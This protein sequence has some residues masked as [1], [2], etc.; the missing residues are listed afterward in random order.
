MC[1]V[2]VKYFA[3][4]THQVRV[5]RFVLAKHFVLAPR[6]VEAKYSCARLASAPMRLSHLPKP[7]E[8]AQLF[9]L[10]L[11]AQHILSLP[12][13]REMASLPV[14]FS[15]VCLTCLLRPFRFLRFSR[16]CLFCHPALFSPTSQMSHQ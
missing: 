1:M 9:L 12:D 14:W 15:Q 16:T 13:R 2:Q 7:F 11:N 3:P 10:A 5:M 6:F 8:F 4:A